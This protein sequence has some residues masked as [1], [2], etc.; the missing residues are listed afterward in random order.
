MPFFIIAAGIGLIDIW[1][2]LENRPR[3]AR[4]AVLGV[5]AAAAVYCIVANLAVA[6]F[7]VSD[8]TIAQDANFVT[9]EKGLSLDSL[10][11]TV[12]HGD[13]LPYWA[14][15]GQLFAMNNCSGLYLSSGNYMKD[16]PGQQIEHFTWSPV[17]QSR[18]F[19]QVIGF[20]F[21]RP[22][23][24]LH[25][26]IPLL[27][28]GASTLVL[29]PE[30]PGY[31]RLQILDSGTSIS[32]PPSVGWN[33]HVIP[34]LVHRRLRTSVTIDPNLNSIVVNWYDNEKMIN[35]YIAGRGPAV[36][37]TTSVPAG[38]PTP[39]VTVV[40]LPNRSTTNAELCRSLLRAN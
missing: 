20:T 16:V 3:R 21:N 14:P 40:Q 4:S 28:Y 35:H 33:L 12:E 29:E 26:R 22:A 9:A 31:V 17:E 36:V 5:T 37:K 25:Q 15:A 6:S 10:R 27:T 18:S 38:S 7:P 34:S 30:A 24:D 32:W 23:A 13:T 19:T 11:S 8:W 39:V 1:R 2:R